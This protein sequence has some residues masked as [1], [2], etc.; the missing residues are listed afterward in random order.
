MQL[1]DHYLDLA[2]A[3]KRATLPPEEVPTTE[4]VARIRL[5]MREEAKANCI[6]RSERGR[7]DCAMRAQTTRG[8]GGCLTGSAGDGG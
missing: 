7:Y 2:M 6:G 3:E 1:L 4:Q 8:L 5:A